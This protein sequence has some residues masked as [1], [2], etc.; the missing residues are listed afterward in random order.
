MKIWVPSRNPITTPKLLTAFK[1]HSEYFYFYL[2]LIYLQ[3]LFW[4]FA[5]VEKNIGT[6]F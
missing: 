4:F 1:F 3:K 2:I 6:M 5:V